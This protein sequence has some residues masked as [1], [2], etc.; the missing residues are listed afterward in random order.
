M[1]DRRVRAT[2]LVITPVAG[3][4]A[5]VAWWPGPVAFV[6]AG[7]YLLAHVVTIPNSAG[8]RLSLTTA[9]A[10]ATALT[11][12]SPVLVV[13]PA[14][15]IVPLGWL[16][17]RVRYGR[18][19]TD[20]MFPAEPTGGLVFAGAFFGIVQFVGD[21]HPS[22]PL[23][24]SAFGVAAVLWFGTAVLVRSA[25][26]QQGRVV[27][28][29]LG[30][31]RAV[32]DWPAYAALFS[33][34]ALFAVTIGP[35]GYW[36][37]PLAGLPYLFSHLSLHRVQDTRRTYEQTIRALGAIP[38]AG[39]HVAPGHSNRTGDLAVA[40]GSEMG[41][42]AAA[43]RRIEYAALLHDIGRVVLANP[44]VAGGGYSRGDVSRW[45]AAIISEAR[46]LE[47]VAAIV[48]SQHQPYRKPGEERDHEVPI[49]SQILRVAARYDSALDDGTSPIEAVE[50]LHQ[51]VAYDY[52]PTVVMA[53]RRV[54]ERRGVIAA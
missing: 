41:L 1:R 12:G 3:I 19:V 36:A 2:L 4:A 31:L 21:F 39:G 48:A 20:D 49:G 37:I 54:L 18:R 24:L 53:L 14:A 34:S 28:R 9:V 27:N 7:A 46:Y 17:V 10:S 15:A 30:R 5:L 45:S 43:L 44:S 8:R 16:A 42:G 26:S 22:H 33:S 52:D 47:P 13:A 6:V 35:M 38:E 50:L 29:R 40:V 23:V 11:T 32:S 51:G 25:W